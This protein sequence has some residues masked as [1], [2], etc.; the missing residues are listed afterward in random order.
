[1][2]SALLFWSGY[3]SAK[4]SKTGYIWLG[5]LEIQCK[6]TITTDPYS[7]VVLERY[8]DKAKLLYIERKEENILGL[9]LLKESLIFQTC[10]KETSASKRQNG[11]LSLMY[12]SQKAWED[13]LKR[14]VL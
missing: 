6:V 11:T 2:S 3:K 13:I 4:G 1:M 10:V 9:F 14:V 5:G 8:K 12:Q 7:K